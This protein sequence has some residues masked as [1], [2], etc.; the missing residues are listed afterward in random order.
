MINQSLFIFTLLSW[1]FFCFLKVLWWWDLISFNDNSKGRRLHRIYKTFWMKRMN[2]AL[3]EIVENS[4]FTKVALTKLNF[5]ISYF[6]NRSLLEFK[7]F[8]SKRPPGTVKTVFTI[9]YQY[10]DSKLC[11]FSQKSY[12]TVSL[13]GSEIKFKKGKQKKVR[14]TTGG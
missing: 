1:W 14:V 2:G 8:S 9:Q 6:K 5:V 3:N 13:S 7:Y 10:H 11:S 12:W 4:I